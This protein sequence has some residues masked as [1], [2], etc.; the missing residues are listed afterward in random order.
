MPKWYLTG[1]GKQDASAAVRS[2]KYI[3][4]KIRKFISLNS[5]GSILIE[6][7]V[8][9]PVL[10]MLLYYIHDLSKLKR[11]YD[12]TEFVAQQTVNMLQ[13]ISQ[14]RS[15]KR[16]KKED[17]ARIHTLAWQT[18]YPGKTLFL[19]DS[20]YPAGYSSVT[21]MYYV[22][23]LSDGKA[24]CRWRTWTSVKTSPNDI[25]YTCVKNNDT[26]SPINYR[27]NADPSTIYPTLNINL[28]EKKI[29]VETLISRNGTPTYKGISDKEAI[30]L[31]LA[32][33]GGVHTNKGWTHLFRSIVI[34]TP[35]EG[36]FNETTAP[37]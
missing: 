28:G 21:S 3:L 9:M 36:L 10:I 20:V 23:G 19:K 5:K 2:Y 8:C 37:E 4:T 6:F 35:K 26:N 12:Q 17:L 7:S 30:G 34:F 29:I 25:S 16:I 22:E 32:N 31:Y 11:Y 15:N 27:T 14:N 1:G 24:S 33:P 13:N 18:L